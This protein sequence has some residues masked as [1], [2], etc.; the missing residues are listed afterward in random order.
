MSQPEPGIPD[1]EAWR[2]F[3]FRAPL[4]TDKHQQERDADFEDTNGDA[5]GEPGAVVVGCYRA[6]G[7][8][9]PD[10]DVDGELFGGGG[11]PGG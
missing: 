5:R 10:D 7:R 4:A 2:L 3:G 6:G 8:D 1:A 11:L 9:A